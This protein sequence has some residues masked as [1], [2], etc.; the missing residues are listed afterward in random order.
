M[1]PDEIQA[2]RTKFMSKRDWKLGTRLGNSYVLTKREV[3][4]LCK[5]LAAPTDKHLPGKPLPPPWDFIRQCKQGYLDIPENPTVI[6][7]ESSELRRKQ[8]L[9][10]CMQGK[11]LPE[12][13]AHSIK[14]NPH[15]V[16]YQSVGG[17]FKDV[18]TLG[19]VNVTPEDFRACVLTDEIW[20]LRWF[21]ANSVWAPT[22]ERAL[23]LAMGPDSIRDV[24]HRTSTESVPPSKDFYSDLAA[25]IRDQ[26]SKAT[27]ASV[28][29]TKPTDT[30]GRHTG[31]IDPDL[32]IR[33]G[34]KRRT[35]R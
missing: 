18:G 29:G 31:L 2:L 14:H 20:E 25:A 16:L 24:G 13:V 7:D 5:Q 28:H 32:R 26:A 22:L 3:Q 17:Y 9:T 35:Q 33:L 4:F 19:N 12:G 30:L 15:R 8:F 34:S 10:D 1:A 27:D 21:P 23:E 11:K 6:K